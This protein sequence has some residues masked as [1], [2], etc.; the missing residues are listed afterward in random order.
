ME[1][2]K[3]KCSSIDHDKVDAI[4]FCNKCEIA[5]WQEICPNCGEPAVPFQ[6]QERTSNE[7]INGQSLVA[8]KIKI[9]TPDGV[10]C[11]LYNLGGM[12]T[13]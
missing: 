5:T 3:L 2:K 9:D 12:E 8:F 11:I 13:I 1:N 10:K 6:G 7:A 4:V